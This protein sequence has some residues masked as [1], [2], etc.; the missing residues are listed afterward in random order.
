ML[1][2]YLIER[3]GV[4]ASGEPVTGRLLARLFWQDDVVADVLLESHVG[5]PCVH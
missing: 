5:Q 2:A 3:G 4:A 1:R